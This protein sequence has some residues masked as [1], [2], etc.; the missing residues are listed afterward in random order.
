MKN[1]WEQRADETA[2][3]YKAFRC[4]L[5]KRSVEGA[6][7]EYAKSQKRRKAEKSG[8]VKKASGAFLGWSKYFEWEARA[9]AYDSHVQAETIKS[10]VKIR[11]QEYAERA[12]IYRS[13]ANK[14]HNAVATKLDNPADSK[15]SE[16]V[17]TA[18][19][20]DAEHLAEMERV[21][22]LDLQGMIEKQTRTEGE[23]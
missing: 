1:A 2:Q 14:A 16:L 13:L 22:L 7:R 10:T 17:E 20:Y 8:A 19:F 6:Y 12:K 5:D 9:A 21:N 3:Q 4:Y 15:L 23:Q 11:R 18:K